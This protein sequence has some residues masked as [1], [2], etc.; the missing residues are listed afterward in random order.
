VGQASSQWFFLGSH[1]SHSPGTGRGSTEI[2]G[3]EGQD[4]RYCGWRRKHDLRHRRGEG[5]APVRRTSVVVADN[6]PIFR[7]GVRHLLERESDFAV[8]EAESFTDLARAVDT[9]EP[10]IALVDLDLP[11]TGGVAA[12]ARL[13]P[14]CQTQMIVWSFDASRDTVIAAIAAGAKG[15]LQKRISPTGLIRSLRGVVRGEAPLPRDLATL[16]IAAVQGLEQRDRVR[17]RAVVL[18]ARERE[19]LALVSRGARNRQIAQSLSISEF[20]VKRHMQNILHKLD[21]PSRRAAALFYRSAFEPD[22][23]PVERIA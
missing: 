4:A 18:S 21:L 12:V 23:D 11:P 2:R 16:M 10:D 19:V 13:A 14:K 7:S 17:E 15:Y 20:T 22:T 5:G 9:E 8:S 6:G 1:D 3:G